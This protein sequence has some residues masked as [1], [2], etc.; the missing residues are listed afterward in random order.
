MFVTVFTTVPPCPYP[1][2]SQT[3]PIH[4]LPSYLRTVF[5]FHIVFNAIPPP[6]ITNLTVRALSFKISQ[7]LS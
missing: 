2:P 1:V 6:S 3:N 4:A 5:T 7:S